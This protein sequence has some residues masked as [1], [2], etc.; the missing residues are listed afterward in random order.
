MTHIY[1]CTW[2]IFLALEETVYTLLLEWNQAAKVCTSQGW[3]VRG[4]CIDIWDIF[5][6]VFVK[7]PNMKEPVV[8]F[9]AQD[10][11]GILEYFN[12]SN[13]KNSDIS[14]IKIQIWLNGLYSHMT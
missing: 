3:E 1:S 13:I 11:S 14:L 6:S 7:G 2:Q 10:Q 4:C 8:L 9:S 12:F 5:E